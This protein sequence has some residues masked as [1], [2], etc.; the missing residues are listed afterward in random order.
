[1]GILPG[2]LTS[3]PGQ[4]SLAIPLWLGAWLQLQ[5]QKNDESCVYQISWNNDLV[6]LLT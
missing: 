4:L 3:H 2:Y 5:L 1:M 6:T